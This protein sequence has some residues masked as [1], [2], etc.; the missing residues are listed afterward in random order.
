MVDAKALLARILSPRMLARAVRAFDRGT[1]VII[2]SSWGGVVFLM[3][4]ALYTLNLSAQAKVQVALALAKEPSLP[5]MVSRP[6][7]IKEMGDVLDRLQKRF[8]EISFTLAPDRSFIVAANEGAK[9]RPW[10]TALSYIDTAYPKIR[11]RIK[12][13]CVGSK[14]SSNMPMRAVLAPEKITFTS[15]AGLGG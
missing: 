12:E 7:D 1:V 6:P 9:F 15:S 10:L 13:L 11:W 2:A 8:P 14:C 5:Q 4:F 3:L